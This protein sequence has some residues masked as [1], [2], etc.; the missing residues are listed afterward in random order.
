MFFRMLKKDL[1]KKKTMNTVLLMFIV[2]ASMF[3]ASGI[4]NVV[5]VMNGTDN[6]L[7]KAG[8]GDFVIITMGGKSEDAE[9]KAGTVEKILRNEKTVKDY[10]IENVVYGSEGNVENISGKKLKAKNTTIF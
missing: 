1:Q 2:L 9:G 4:N 7:D 8:I 5:T 3:L 10:R 6:Y